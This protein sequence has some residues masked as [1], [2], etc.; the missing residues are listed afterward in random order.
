MR[1]MGRTVAAENGSLGAL[2][3]D[4]TWAEAFAE[5]RVD[6]RRPARVVT[7]HRDLWLVA[8]LADSVDPRPATISGRLR[9]DAAGPA[10]LPTVED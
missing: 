6:G 10:D 1:A 3:W 9:F 7:S 4:A 5:V 2:G 8:G